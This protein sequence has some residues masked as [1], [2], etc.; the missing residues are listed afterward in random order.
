MR[1]LVLSLA[2]LS[3]LRIWHC[4]ELFSIVFGGGGACGVHPQH[5]QFPRLG[6]K[7]EPQLLA[8]TTATAMPDPNLICE[9]HHSH[10][11]TGSKLYVQLMMQFVAMLDPLPT[12]Q[13]QGSNQQP[14]GS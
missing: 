9:L 7:S 6:V 1:R 8:Y 12:E 4:P 14:H 11:N 5:M 13:S 10:S 3:G 2:S